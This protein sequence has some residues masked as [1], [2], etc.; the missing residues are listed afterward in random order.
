MHTSLNYTIRV[1]HDHRQCG[2]PAYVIGLSLSAAVAE[3][4]SQYYYNY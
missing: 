3:E 2:L 4:C 1:H